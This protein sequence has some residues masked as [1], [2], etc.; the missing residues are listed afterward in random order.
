MKK[1]VKIQGAVRAFAKAP[2]IYDAAGATK[3]ERFEG[4]R[5]L[6]RQWADGFWAALEGGIGE[7]VWRAPNPA[8]ASED[9][10]MVMQEVDE[11]AIAIGDRREYSFDLFF[12]A[13]RDG[14]FRAVWAMRFCRIIFRHGVC[15]EDALIRYAYAYTAA[16]KVIRGLMDDGD[17][18]ASDVERWRTEVR[19]VATELSEVVK[20]MSASPVRRK[21]TMISRHYLA[22]LCN[23]EEDLAAAFAEARDSRMR[24]D[25]SC[26]TDEEYAWILHDCLRQAV[27]KFK[28]R[29]LVELFL[30]EIKAMPKNGLPRNRKFDVGAVI[31]SDVAY[32]E[33]FLDGTLEARGMVKIGEVTKAIAAL[34]EKTAEQPDNLSLKAAFVDLCVTH[35]EFFKEFDSLCYLLC[36]ADYSGKPAADSR[37]MAKVVDT[38]T[39]YVT[40]FPMDSKRRLS[41]EGKMWPNWKI[42][43]LALAPAYVEFVKDWVISHLDDSD[44]RCPEDAKGRSGRSRSERI[45]E[46]L[47]KCLINGVGDDSVPLLDV[48]GWAV[49]F[50]REESEKA[51]AWIGDVDLMLGRLELAA[52]NLDQARTRLSMCIA[53]KPMSGE[54]W[55]W[56]GKTFAQDDVGCVRCMAKVVSLDCRNRFA[57]AAH[58]GLAAYFESA[59]RTADAA[60]EFAAA[61]SL[62]SKFGRPRRHDLEVLLGGGQRKELKATHDVELRQWASE[63]AGLVKV[64]TVTYD[65]V[66]VSVRSGAKS[67]R[68]YVPKMAAGRF[69]SLESSVFGTMNPEAGMPVTIE[70]VDGG[71]A[72]VCGCRPRPEGTAWDVFPPTVGIVAEADYDYGFVR[73]ALPEDRSVS[74][75]VSRCCVGENLKI[76]DVVKLRYEVH[77]GRIVVLS[78]EKDAESGTMPDFLR[79]VS[80]PL[81]RKKSRC[82]FGYVEDVFVPGILCRE[83]A[84]ASEIVVWAVPA[85]ATGGA[86]WQAVRMEAT[87]I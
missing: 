60:C 36:P 64:P 75:E 23:R 34:E 83:T 82:E 73:I 53:R 66:V 17:L 5:R 57:V 8:D 6:K 2:M 59:G 86:P 27:S 51:S 54:C 39:K 71:D 63:A 52:G 14:G 70:V 55:Y 50:I 79:R 47:F 62:L 67:A 76:G 56:F 45:C 42:F 68:I 21:W 24:G 44:R 10:A 65:A 37:P 81:L 9:G 78:C 49:R 32:G 11:L 26:A 33:S 41:V 16:I 30:S 15:V 13:C 19:L 43:K 38:V 72:T 25:A 58:E 48:D 69:L 74:V 3:E 12:Q 7:T 85:R 28:N 29:Q 87:S 31:D 1:V 4:Y 22:A 84:T 40:R 80:G 61:D 35:G 77:G 20:R 46:C 18:S